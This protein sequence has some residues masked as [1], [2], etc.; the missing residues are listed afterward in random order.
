MLKFNE[1]LVKI[2]EKRNSL[3]KMNNKLKNVNKQIYKEKK[4]LSILEEQLA[5]EKEDVTR[6]ESTFSLNSIF[7]KIAGDYDEELSR[8]KREFYEAQAKVLESRDYLQKLNEDRGKFLADIE[9]MKNIDK[10]YT[11]VLEMKKEY[12]MQFDNKHTAKITAFMDEVNAKKLQLKEIQEAY[13]EGEI[14]LPLV[15]NLISALQAVKKWSKWNA[16]GSESFAG[17]IKKGKMDMAAQTANAIKIQLSRYSTE[18]ADLKEDSKS[19]ISAKSLSSLLEY[20]FEN[21]FTDFFVNNNSQVALSN[22]NDLLSTIENMQ[23]DLRAEEEQCT[24][25]IELFSKRVENKLVD[26]Y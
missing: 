9:S 17:T 14:L 21:I 22:A 25:D 19:S 12:L 15:S 1:E 10:E 4:K 11:Q 7:V 23:K 6:L 8:E 16:I 26:I 24:R 13:V 3:V 18:L 20:F 2:E 5:K